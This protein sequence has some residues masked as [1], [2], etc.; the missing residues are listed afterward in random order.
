[1]RITSITINTKN[2][3]LFTITLEL[4]LFTI[5]YKK[6]IAEKKYKNLKIN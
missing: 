6:V 5:D 1:M 3:N 2:K 4:K